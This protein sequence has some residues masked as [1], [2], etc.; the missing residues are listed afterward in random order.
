MWLPSSKTARKRFLT[1]DKPASAYLEFAKRTKNARAKHGSATVGRR[2]TT[3]RYLTQAKMD[4]IN[5]LDG[6]SEQQINDIRDKLIVKGET[7]LDGD[8]QQAATA[9]N[10]NN[11]SEYGLINDLDEEP[12]VIDRS[13]DEGEAED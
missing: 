4:I 3:R 8:R 5:K 2:K 7:S 11:Q 1:G 9:L 12:F 6:L 13:E 10:A